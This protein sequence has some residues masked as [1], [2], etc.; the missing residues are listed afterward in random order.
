MSS[1]SEM[2]VY[3]AVQITEF[4]LSHLQAMKAALQHSAQRRSDANLSEPEH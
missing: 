4:I 2:C 1:W 3:T